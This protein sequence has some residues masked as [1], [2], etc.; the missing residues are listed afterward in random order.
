MLAGTLKDDEYDLDLLYSPAAGGG[1]L[2][3][4]SLIFLV[5]RCTFRHS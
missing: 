3:F 1:D 2:F 4:L 5:P